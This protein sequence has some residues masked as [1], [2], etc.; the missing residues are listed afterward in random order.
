MNRHAGANGVLLLAALSAGLL[1]D[2]MGI[3]R[4][5][6]AAS[7]MHEA[8][9]VLA[10]VLCTHNMPRLAPSLGGVS[11]CMDKMLAR[12]QELAVVCAG[13]IRA[14]RRAPSSTPNGR[15]LYRPM[16]R[17]TAAKK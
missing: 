11:L 7:V 13:T 5:A 14:S 2:P 3:L 4:M 8:G 16:H 1:F 6:L 15:Q 9:H 17:C 10:Y 12:R